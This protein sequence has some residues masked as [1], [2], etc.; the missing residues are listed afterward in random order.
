MNQSDDLKVR[1]EQDEF[2]RELVVAMRAVD[3]PEGFAERVMVRARQVE[4]VPVRAKLLTMTMRVRIWS[5]G[6]VAASL[7]VG[8]FFFAQQERQRHQREEAAVAAEQFDAAMRITD[9]TLEHTQ[10]Q[11]WNA[12]VRFGN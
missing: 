8:G 5:V 1:F 11:L 10:Q 9:H 7:L 12:G 3:P 2:E 4:S 6:A